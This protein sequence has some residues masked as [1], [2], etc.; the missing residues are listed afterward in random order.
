MSPPTDFSQKC[1]L[2]ERKKFLT[3]RKVCKKDKKCILCRI[4]LTQIMF[5]LIGV[6]YKSLRFM[7]YKK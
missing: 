6:C 1:S 7:S 5:A 4:G 3:L 2:N